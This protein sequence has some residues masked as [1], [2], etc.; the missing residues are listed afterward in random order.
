MQLVKLI[1]HKRINKLTAVYTVVLVLSIT[2]FTPAFSQDNS[3]YSRFGMGDLVPNANI[4]NRGMGGISAGYS[5]FL[6]INFNN[7]ASYSNFQSWI[8]KR[9]KKIQSGR[10]LLDVGVNYDSRTIQEPGNTAKFTS[11]NALFSYLQ[12][13]VPIKSNWGLVFGL[14]PVSRIGYKI[15]SRTKLINPLPPFN[16]I[17]SAV[18]LF[19][20]TGG[21]YVASVGTGLA[22]YKKVKHKQEEKLSIGVNMGYMFGNKDYSSRRSIF[23]DSLVEYYKAN[24]QTVA[25]FGSLHFDAGLQYKLPLNEKMMLTLGAYGAWAQKLN[26]TQDVLRETFDYDQTTGASLQIDSVYQLK[27]VKGKIEMPANYTL[28]FVLQKFVIPAKEGGWLIGIDFSKQNWSKY[29]YYGQAENLKDQWSLKVGGQFNPKPKANNYLSNITYRFGF[30]TGADPISQ[31][32]PFTQTGA[33]F[34]MALPLFN[35]GGLTQQ[36]TMVNLALEYSRRGKNIN[37]LKEN[38]FRLALGFSLSDL[39]FG[40]KK[41]D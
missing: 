35:R 17:D 27:N 6:S 20:G 41:Y 38:M 13:G 29:R 39:W 7:P 36:F 31:L 18:T 4:A 40:K 2:V 32:Q 37:P 9:S 23:N 10:A 34:G 22:I 19:E 15:T 12:L 3:P 28:G 33:T 11:N 30:F 16:A 26:A 5:D 25:N 1:T 8:E 14:R 21:S 24:Y